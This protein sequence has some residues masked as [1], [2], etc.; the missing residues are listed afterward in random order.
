MVPTIPKPNQHIV[1]Q[2]W[3]HFGWIW[4]GKAEPP[5]YLNLNIGPFHIQILSPSKYH[6]LNVKYRH[7]PNTSNQSGC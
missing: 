1:I 2:N 3:S 4:N 5:L 7:D 6:I